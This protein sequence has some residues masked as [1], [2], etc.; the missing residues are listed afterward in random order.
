MPETKLQSTGIDFLDDM[1]DGG[2]AP[3][4]M[5]LVLGAT[6]VGKT[7]LGLSY[8]YQGRSAEGHPGCIVD[9]TT[10]GDSQQH[11]EY[12]RRLFGWDIEEGSVEPDSIFTSK[13]ALPEK[14]IGLG[15]TG[16]RVTRED[17]TE[18]QWRQWQARLNSRLEAVSSFLYAHFVRGTRRVLLD[19]IEPYSRTAESAQ[20]ELIEYIYQEILRNEFDWVARSVFQGRWLEVQEKVQKQ[21]YDCEEISTMALQT[22]HET[23]LEDLIARPL[24]PGDLAANANTIILLGRLR[25]G[26]ET[27]RGAFVLKHRGRNCSEKTVSFEITDRG[28]KRK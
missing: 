7:Q 17:L 28:L 15:Y 22:T 1:L 18:D 14:F 20:L 24:P 25:Q 12:A 3:G 9:F 13:N 27:S 8:L 26:E 6:G 10:R 11:G 23:L 4:T 5:T 2:L 16:S 19:S 21:A